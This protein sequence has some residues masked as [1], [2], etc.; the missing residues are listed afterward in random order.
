MPLHHANYNETITLLLEDSTNID[1]RLCMCDLLRLL[2]LQTPLH[3][4]SRYGYQETIAVLLR[5]GANVNKKDDDGK[6]NAIQI[7]CFPISFQSH[8]ESG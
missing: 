3:V 1:E 2:H 6:V 5:H 8:L 7:S 4:A